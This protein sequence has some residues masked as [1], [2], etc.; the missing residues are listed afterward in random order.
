M[1]PEPGT[2]FESRSQNPYI[3]KALGRAWAWRWLEA[4]EAATI[5]DIAKTDGFIDRFASRMMRLACLSPDVLER[6][7]ITRDPLPVPVPVN[8]RLDCF[9]LAEEQPTRPGRVSPMEQKALRL[10]ADA[11]LAC[12]R[13]RPL[14]N[15]LADFI[16]EGVLGDGGAAFNRQYSTQ[17]FLSFFHMTMTGRCPL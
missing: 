2:H 7:V 3:L 15:M 13:P 6:L 4:G 1:P 8:E 12:R 14:V 17:H 16:D 9:A 5:H 10:G 11:P